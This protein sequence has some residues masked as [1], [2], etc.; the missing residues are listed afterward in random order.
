MKNFVKYI[1]GITL[2]LYSTS[3]DTDFLNVKPEDRFSESSVWKDPGLVE[4]FVNEMYRGLNHGIRELMLGSLADESQFIHNYGSAQVVQSNLTSGDIGSFSRGDFEEFNWPVLYARIRQINLFLENIEA[5]P[6]D[7]AAWKDRLKGEVHFL[8]AYFYHNLVRLYGGVPLVTKAYKLKDEFLIKRSSLQESIQYIVDECDLAASLLPLDYSSSA[9]DIGRATRGAALALKS[10][11]LLYAASELYN[12]PSWAA[13]YSNPE[14]IS[15]TGDRTA[16][17]LAAKNAAKAVIDL[18]IYSLQNTG[19]PVKDYTDVF[20]LK[21]SKE[22]IFSRYFIK[23]R[24]WEDGALPGLANGPNGYHNW[25]GNT[26]IQ[27]LVDDYEMVDGSKFDWNNPAHA[28][29]PYE[30]RDPRLSA[31]I[32]YDQALWRPRPSDVKDI[33]PVGKVIIRSVETAPGVWTPGLDTRDGPIED[34]NG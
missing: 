27:E 9:D 7:D 10:R 34:W 22:G 8:N 6:F 13:G 23:S 33:D 25:G 5:A 24:G 3:C 17:W 31:S 2:V 18:G 29:A 14:L 1:L 28:A 15:A 11:I 30:N 19:T 12:N 21:D 26:P 20:L 4:A 16:K 32:L